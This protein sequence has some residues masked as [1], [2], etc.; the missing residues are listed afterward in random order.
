[1]MSSSRIRRGPTQDSGAAPRAYPLVFVGAGPGD[2]ELVTRKG[3]HTLAQAD[4]VLHDALLDAEGFR[5][6]APLARWID[7]GK[8]AGRLSTAQ[9]FITRLL[10]SL[11]LRGHR[12][13]R[14]KGGDVSIFGRL[15]EEVQACRQAGLAVEIV[16][17]VTA[18]SGCAAELGISL[19]Q[20]EVAR[21]VTFLTPRTRQGSEDPADHWVTSALGSDTAVLYMA[22]RDWPAM[23]RQLL[24]R[25]KHPDTPVAWVESASLQARRWI[26]T[27]GQSAL[28]APATGAG[29]VT[30]VIGQVVANAVAD[31]LEAA[32]APQRRE[33]S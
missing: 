27:L 12:V 21:S 25:G 9:G 7:V 33:Q 19:T 13:V 16:P 2:P 23:A 5:Q 4:V 18:A 32:T 28:N 20:R 6:A 14:L 24:Q 30:V 8:R 11:A 26:G 31:R 17:G 3:W 15:S 29:P 1:M 22:G 10:V